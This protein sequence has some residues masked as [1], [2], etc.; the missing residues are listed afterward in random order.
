MW[1]NQAYIKN[2]LKKVKSQG[3]HEDDINLFSDVCITQETQIND[4]SKMSHYC[5]VYIFNRR[6]KCVTVCMERK[7]FSYFS[8]CFMFLKCVVIFCDN[9]YFM[10]LKLKVCAKL[11]L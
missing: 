10:S 1:N 3:D 9:C 8:S 5:R 2:Y 4:F 11:T 6:Y 7:I